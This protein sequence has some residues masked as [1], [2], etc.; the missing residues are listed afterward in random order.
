MARPRRRDKRPHPAGTAA[1]NV[2][3]PGPDDCERTL[4][5]AG[6]EFLRWVPAFD[7]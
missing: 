6:A 1:L 2:G 3:R 5:D 4:I 7:A